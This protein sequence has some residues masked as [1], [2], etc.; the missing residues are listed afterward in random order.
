MAL[1]ALKLMVSFCG[2]E[3]LLMWFDRC[4]PAHFGWSALRVTWASHVGLPHVNLSQN[5]LPLTQWSKNTL[6]VPVI[7]NEWNS[8]WYGPHQD[9][10]ML[11][12]QMNQE[13]TVAPI[14][15]CIYAPILFDAIIYSIPWICVES[16]IGRYVTNRTSPKFLCKFN[17]LLVLML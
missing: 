4:S 10:R 2:S 13:L 7:L 6:H 1:P 14:W 8:D 16:N 3:E 15:S 11:N 9:E 17:C 12:Q 5:Y